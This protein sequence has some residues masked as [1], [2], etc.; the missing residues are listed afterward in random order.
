MHAVASSKA[1]QPPI[2]P[3]SMLLAGLPCSAVVFEWLSALP[4]M[5]GALRSSEAILDLALAYF[6]W[7]EAISAATEGVKGTAAERA[8][9]ALDIGL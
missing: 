8:W 3:P 2:Q 9:S 6:V 4:P 5:L 1:I 7:D